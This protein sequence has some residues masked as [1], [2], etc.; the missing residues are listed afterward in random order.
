MLRFIVCA[1]KLLVFCV[2]ST[3]TV[4]D[5]ADEGINP[6]K[7]FIWLMQTKEAVDLSFLRS[8][9]SDAI[10]VASFIHV[11]CRCYSIIKQAGCLGSRATHRL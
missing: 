5:F 2:Q 3:S 7:K 9:E 4:A 8:H 6:T 1:L 11:P 10:Q